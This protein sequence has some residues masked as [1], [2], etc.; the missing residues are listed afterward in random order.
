MNIV[1]KKD[2]DLSNITSYE[3]DFVPNMG[4]AIAVFDVSPYDKIHGI[5][6]RRFYD[7]EHNV[8]TIYIKKV[9]I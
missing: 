9:D 5:V 2:S 6:V 3:S 4:D 1:V 7:Q 8:V